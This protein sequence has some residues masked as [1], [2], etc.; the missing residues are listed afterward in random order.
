MWPTED[1]I[2]VKDGMLFRFLLANS[3]KFGL[4]LLVNIARD[5]VSLW[6]PDVTSLYEWEST[7][8]YN[9]F[10]RPHLVG[11]IKLLFYPNSDTW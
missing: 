10:K 3:Y 6:H 1:Y 9:P 4:D 5:C 2:T 8:Y 7:T 11:L